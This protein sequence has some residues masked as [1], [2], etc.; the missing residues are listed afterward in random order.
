[1]LLIVRQVTEISIPYTHCTSATG[2][3]SCA[4]EVKSPAFYQA[5][6]TCQC[7][8]NFTLTSDMQVI[9]LSCVLTFIHNLELS[10]N[11]DVHAQTQTLSMNC[12]R[13][14]MI[15]KFHHIFRD[16]FTCFMV[17]QTSTKI[18]GDMLCPAMMTNST[19]RI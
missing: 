15:Y 13:R 17:Y 7:T 9:I 5:F 11:L 8:I 6:K 14:L 3:V 4:E 10:I 1:M 19:A 12:L 16:P 18:I 2:G